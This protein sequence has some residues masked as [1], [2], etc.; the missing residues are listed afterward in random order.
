[1]NNDFFNRALLKTIFLDFE[2][3]F[4]L[5][6][7]PLGRFGVDFGSPGGSKKGSK[8]KKVATGPSILGPNGLWQ[9]SWHHFEWILTILDGIGE[10]W[11]R[12]LMDL[13][14]ILDV[15]GKLFCKNCVDFRGLWGEISF[16]GVGEG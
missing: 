8:I 12:F 9:A 13:G 3:L 10:V 5:F 1:M 14:V 16:V 15:L 11:G 4:G 2:A 6:G 7:V